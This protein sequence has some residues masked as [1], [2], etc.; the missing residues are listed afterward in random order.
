MANKKTRFPWK[1]LIGFL[2]SITLTLVALWAGL[3]AGFSMT[4]IITI[5]T[6]LAMC[7]AVLQLLMFMHMTE[8][9]GTI[10]TGTMLYAAFIGVV[11]VAGTIWVMSFGMH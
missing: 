6:V 8:G 2:L 7:Q 3:Y 11:V 9:E 1:H 4:V 10:Q 5:I